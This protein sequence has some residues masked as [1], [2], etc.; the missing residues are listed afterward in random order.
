MHN[1][2]G[3]FSETNYIYGEALR[4]AL[5]SDMPQL[6]VL[7]VGLGLGYNE[8]L[9][10]SHFI[11]ARAHSRAV[12][13]AA[14]EQ[15]E[16]Q[17]KSLQC[18]HSYETDAFLKQ[19]FQHWLSD[20]SECALSEEYDVI[21]SLYAKDLCLGANQIK[22]Q[23]KDWLDSK[24]LCLNDTFS[25]TGQATV[26]FHVMYYDPFSAKTNPD[27]WSEQAIRQFFT[28]W[29]AEDCVVSTYAATGDLKRAL[30]AEGFELVKRP[31]FGGKRESFLGVRGRVQLV[32]K[33]TL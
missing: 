15:H 14:I 28:N 6:R 11:A 4:L 18:L 16:Q 13:R 1:F 10:A 12:D 7:S 25:V 2:H 31:G 27:F 3:A 21:C 5:A 26:P 33:E 32:P 24:Q 29:A 19:A 22:T 20:S 9:T 30:T 23:L 17:Q 8:V